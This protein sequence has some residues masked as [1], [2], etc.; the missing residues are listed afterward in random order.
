MKTIKL[1]I[2]NLASYNEGNTRGTWFTLPVE[3]DDVVSELFTVNELDENGN[4]ISDW[5]IHDFESPVP[6]S[7]F[8]SISELNE[9]ARIFADLTE[10][11]VSI[12]VALQE[13]GTIKD[14]DQAKDILSSITIYE[15]CPTMN[16]VA[17]A[18]VEDTYGYNDDIQPLLRH[19]DY[20]SYVEEL[21][22]E[23]I[24][25]AINEDTYVQYYG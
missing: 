18:I 16:D 1:Y 15:Q 4:P 12:L 11:E 7:E 19:I 10:Q 23:G 3:W 5:A 20:D 24:Y 25:V 6:V 8:S 22:S 21:E 14:L 17:V 13:A 9:T 2:V